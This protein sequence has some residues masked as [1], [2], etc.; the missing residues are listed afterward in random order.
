MSETLTA[1]QRAAQFAAST[2]QNFQTMP[3][4]TVTS[5]GGN[6]TFTLPKARLLSKILLTVKVNFSAFCPVSGE[7]GLS[8]P[9][10]E[11]LSLYRILR[12]VSLD[13][14]NGFSPYSVGGEEL[15][16]LDCVHRPHAEFMTEFVTS[17]NFSSKRN[18]V[19]SMPF[20]LEDDGK[21]FTADGGKTI[22]LSFGI[23]LPIT[24]NDRDSI[25]MILLQNQ[26][27]YATLSVDIG[28]V[29]D[30]FVGGFTS[31]LLFTLNKVEI[32]PVLETFSI[33]ASG[34]YPDLSVLK[35]V[36]SRTESLV[37]G[38]QHVIKL[39]T[40]TIYRRILIKVCDT[41]NNGT[42]DIV[43]SN[44]ALIFNQADSFYEISAEQLRYLNTQQYGFTLPDGIYV[45]DFAFQG[46]AGLS[47]SRDFVDTERLTEFWLRFNTSTDARVKL[48]T[49]TLA[50]L[51]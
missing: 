5:E 51:S 11:M 34:V 4:Q 32:S 42:D 8:L 39:S 35:L 44:F 14:N 6:V 21:A 9:A 13:L 19:H 47:G 50:R 37:G 15:A 3:T 23:E 49:E 7:T 45:F 26:E 10:N 28:Q 33:P 46:I 38:G 2:R 30:M 20:R 43:T 22:E 1:S 12:R 25:G 36:N 48:V 40:G 18:S 31:K 41:D 16:M 24:L 29:T 27:T 17:N